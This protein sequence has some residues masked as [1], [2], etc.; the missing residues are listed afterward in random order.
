MKKFLL[1][2]L[3]LSGCISTQNNQQIQW[4]NELS[5]GRLMYGKVAP[6]TEIFI[7]NS[8]KN[9][10]ME[11]LYQIPTKEG[12]FVV[13]IPQDGTKL[14]LKIKQNGQMKVFLKTVGLNIQN[15]ACLQEII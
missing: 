15:Q 6:N 11:G 9:N 8:A 10:G 1:L 4:D 7:D 13:G 14:K 2:F 3:L 12:R 5:D